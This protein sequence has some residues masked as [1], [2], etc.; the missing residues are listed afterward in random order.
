[1]SEHSRYQ[2]DRSARFDR[3]DRNYTDRD[4]RETR[5]EYDTSRN[6]LPE[7]DVWNRRHSDRDTSQYPELNHEEQ[8]R[9][10]QDR[11]EP[12]FSTDQHH[13]QRSSQM[14]EN[15]GDLPYRTKLEED[16]WIRE[17]QGRITFNDSDLKD[18]QFT[19]HSDRA[20]KLAAYTGVAAMIGLISLAGFSTIPDLSP[21]EIIAMEGYAGEQPIK[22][23]FNLASLHDCEAGT[24]CA[25]ALQST[26]TPVTA[27]P[28][29]QAAPATTEATQNTSAATSESS[30]VIRNVSDDTIEYVEVR[31]IPAATTEIETSSLDTFN[32]DAGLSDSMVVL[33]QWS[34]VRGTPDIYGEILTSLAVGK[35][36]TKIGQSGPWIEVQVDERPS[37]TGY[38]H[39]STIAV[40]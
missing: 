29:T 31:E 7:D 25:E 6:S 1:M 37:V 21:Q 17:K 24:E 8:H 16:V 2:R 9:Y 15:R 30:V 32:T 4:R 33:Q 39:R 3:G 14:Q 34:N 26:V 36:V 12:V 23:P 28:T 10:D 18:I 40:Q 35:T 20:K 11:Y 13:S 38:M 22:T 5:A 27:D 19:P